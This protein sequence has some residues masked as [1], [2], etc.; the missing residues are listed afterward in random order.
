MAEAVSGRKRLSLIDEMKIL[1]ISALEGFSH[2]SNQ[3]GF[4]FLI[5]IESPWFTSNH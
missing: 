4:V 2:V 1:R 3:I 5:A